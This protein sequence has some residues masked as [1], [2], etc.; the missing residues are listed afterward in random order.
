[1]PVRDPAFAAVATPLG[2]GFRCSPQPS[3]AALGRAAAHPVVSTSANRSGEP[4]CRTAAEVAV[5]FGAG[6][7]ILGG[8]PATGLAPS[9]VVA[10]RAGG[11][12][13]LLRSGDLGLA[14]LRA[15]AGL[16]P[17]GAPK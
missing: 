17:S 5:C 8:E 2:V 7:A 14:E 3:A 13:E 15:A 11:E 4:P 1:V 12:L 10:V 6:L 9:S 16:P